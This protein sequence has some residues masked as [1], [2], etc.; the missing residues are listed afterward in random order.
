MELPLEHRVQLAV[1]AHIRHQYTHYDQHLKVMPY[2]QARSTVGAACVKILKEWRGEGNAEDG[3]PEIEEIIREVIVLD[4]DDDD[5]GYDANKGNTS[6]SSPE[7][8][9]RQQKPN[10]KMDDVIDLTSSSSTIR[11]GELNADRNRDHKQQQ[12]ANQR[13]VSLFSS[14]V[15]L[16]T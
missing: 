14:K 16:L 11:P 3:D 12:K 6:D 8:A 13:C 15:F 4:D 2:P 10:T 7:Q 1:C 5:D 9:S